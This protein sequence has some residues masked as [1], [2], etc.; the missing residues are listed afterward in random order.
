MLKTDEKNGDFENPQKIDDLPENLTISEKPTIEET[1]IVLSDAENAALLPEKNSGEV[2]APVVEETAIVPPV[3]QPTNEKPAKKN[4]VEKNKNTT[5]ETKPP[6]V[7]V[8]TRTS[9]TVNFDNDEFPEL[10]KV[11]KARLKA[12]IST[13]WNHFIR[14]LIQFGLKAHTYNKPYF[15]QPDD[16]NVNLANTF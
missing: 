7:I 14:Q 15:G 12:G 10:D 13:D 16:T 4:K 8:K 2:I 6:K 9:K 5:K 11:F 3:I 1:V